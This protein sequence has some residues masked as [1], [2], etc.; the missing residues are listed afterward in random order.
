MLKMSQYIKN[1]KEVP[2]DD[3]LHIGTRRFTSRLMVGTGKYRSSSEAVAAVAASGAEIVTVALRRIN[4]A[5]KGEGAITRILPQERY[6]YLPNTAGCYTAEEAV[7]TL[8][9]AQELGDYKL[10]KLEVIGDKTT[11]YPDVVETVKAAERLVKDGFEVMAYTSDDPLIAKRL[12]EIGCVAVM[13]LGSPIG[14]GR[15]IANPYNIRTIVE[16]ATI[17]VILDAGIG[18]ASHAA[19]AME[20]GCD[21]VLMNTA[22]AEARDAVRMAHAMKWAVIAG[23]EA[24]LAGRM[25][26]RAVAS[27]SSPE[28]GILKS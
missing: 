4:L 3:G 12:E 24:Y 5:D 26:E 1:V 19:Q 27:A 21:A 25:N 17:P 15:G 20:L 22:I 10:V 18:T 7:R 16:R 2:E 23:R 28:K 13:P 6:T 11:L 9:L 14:S 8:H